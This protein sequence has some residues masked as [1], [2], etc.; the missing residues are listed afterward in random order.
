MGMSPG[1]AS[2]HQRRSGRTA[3]TPIRGAH[4]QL[5]SVNASMPVLHSGAPSGLG[6]AS[7]RKPAVRS[8]PSG[9]RVTAGNLPTALRASEGCCRNIVIIPVRGERGSGIH[10]YVDCG[11][12]CQAAKAGVPTL[13]H[14]DGVDCHVQ[15]DSVLRHEP[16]QGAVYGDIQADHSADVLEVDSDVN[17]DGSAAT[18]GLPDDFGMDSEKIRDGRV[19][20]GRAS[21]G[22]PVPPKPP[23]RLRHDGRRP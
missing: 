7:A 12:L 9:L 14:P 21:P 6:G 11:P 1:A 10:Q 4:A 19:M 23:E 2:E 8:T 3:V 18:H 17:L 15:G 22:S 16:H 13:R 5:L 20:G